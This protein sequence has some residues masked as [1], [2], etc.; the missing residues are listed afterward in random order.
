MGDR[1]YGAPAHGSRQCE[2][3]ILGVD[4]GRRKSA[5]RGVSCPGRFE[6]LLFRPLGRILFSLSTG[7]TFANVG[8]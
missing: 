8:T 5:R 2:T 7:L 6:F 1:G 4:L 3:R